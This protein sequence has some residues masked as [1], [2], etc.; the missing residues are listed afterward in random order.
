M[1][2]PVKTSCWVLSLVV[3]AG[4]LTGCAVGPDFHRPQPPEA[5]GYS[6]GGQPE[7]TVAAPVPG[8]AAQHFSDGADIPAQWWSLFHSEPLDRLVRKGLE[9]SPTL[10]QARARLVQAQEELKA[11]AGADRYPAVDANL[12]ATRQKLD[13]ASLGVTSVPNPGPFT[14]YNA[15]VSVSYT[16]D[17]GF[18]PMSI[19]RVTALGA[20]LVCSVE[21]TK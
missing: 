9:A 10:A 7:A 6:P 1:N 11:Q 20:S 5:S 2:V 21:K 18:T 4:L 14:L 8:G 3:L 15:S 16:L 17:N 12:A 13:L 19:N